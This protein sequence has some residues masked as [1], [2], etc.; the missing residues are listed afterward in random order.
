MSFMKK[1]PGLIY[2]LIT[3]IM[4]LLFVLISNL[5][6]PKYETDTREGG[7]IR[8]FYEERKDFDVVFVG[9][10][11]VYENFSP[12]VLWDEYGINS[13]I[14]GSAEQYIFQSYYILEDTFRY[15]HPKVA[16]FNVQ[17]LERDRSRS[18]AYNRMT[19]DGM[20]W[21][22]SKV[23][24]IKASMT[25][26]EHFTEYLFPILRFHSRWKE[27]TSADVKFMFRH[28]PVT[29]NGY[30]MRVDSLPAGE[31]PS[32]KPLADSSF[33]ERA[34]S[35]LDR[36]RALCEDNG[37]EFL[38]IKAPSLFPHWYDEWDEQVRAYAD[39]KHLKYV[40][41]LEKAGEIGIDYSSDTYDRGMHMNKDGAEKCASFLGK[42]MCDTWEMK[43]RRTEK[44]LSMIWKEKKERYEKEIERQEALYGV[45]D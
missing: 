8:E 24:C 36:M 44:D 6:F 33:S 30:Y 14:R 45:S 40:N 23:K 43:D 13:Y 7:M 15:C 18:E 1:H 19:I 25:E 4:I 22:A 41:L 20:K 26:G 5:L 31:L 11:E 9:D 38:L 32:V 35:Y 10:C 39:E 2:I 34:W 37:T 28:D 12:Q 17:S 29:F 3:I 42:V 21:S 16:V 27:L